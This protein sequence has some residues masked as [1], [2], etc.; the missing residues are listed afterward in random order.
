MSYRRMHLH[1]LLEARRDEVMQR[2]KANARGT[3]AP[4]SMPSIEL[5]DHL[6]Q[7]LLEIITTLR[8][9]AR[10]LPAESGPISTAADHGEQRLRLGFSLDSVVREYGLMRDAIIATARDAGAELTFHQLQI[11]HDCVITGIADA[12][13]QYTRQRDAELARHANEHFAFIAHELRN[14][15]ASAMMAF[16]M[17]KA[18]GQLPNEGKAASALERGLRRTSD[19]IDQTLV[20]ARVASG[21]ELHRESTTLAALI[22]DVELGST[23]EAEAKEIA[24]RTTV[25]ADAVLEV[26]VRLVRSALGNLVRNAVK[27]SHAGATVEI[28]GTVTGQHAVIEV[29]DGCGGLPPGMVEKAFAPFVRFDASAGGFGL[30]LAIAKQ[31]ADAHGGGIRIQNLPGHGCIFALELPLQVP[32]PT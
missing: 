29:E 6:P 1:E 10:A 20:V 12:V 2:W 18:K 24:L 4:D 16:N 7:F 23:S 8:R 17:M 28:R 25:P 26:D 30:G 13:S 11:I 15:L 31:A 27:Y 9:D 5:L 22:A 3:L 14:P 21:I 32:V 19:L